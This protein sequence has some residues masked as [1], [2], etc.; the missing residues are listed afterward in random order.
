MIEGVPIGVISASGIAA[1]AVLSIIRGWLIPSKQA[2]E[3]L[4][5]VKRERDLWREAHGISEEA[6]RLQTSQID[7]LLENT[8][9][10]AQFI[11]S[12]PRPEPQ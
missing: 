10:S 5:D 12:L 4:A 3:R 11:R 6:R 2:D 9:V 1:L 7:E 8:R